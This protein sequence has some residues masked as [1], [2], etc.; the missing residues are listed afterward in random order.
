MLMAHPAVL[1]NLLERYEA[2]QILAD[3]GVGG[4]RVH[5]QLQDAGYALCVSMGAVDIESA[6][7]AARQQ[8]GEAAFEILPR[9]RGAA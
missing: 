1:R 4:S 5:H 8:V 3:E 6:L 9:S 2:L 7:D